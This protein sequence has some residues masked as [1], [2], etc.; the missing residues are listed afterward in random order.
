MDLT[1]IASQVNPWGYVVL[2]SHR[3]EQR[4]QDSPVTRALALPLFTGCTF[5]I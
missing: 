3:G 4:V 1:E 5:K 2:R